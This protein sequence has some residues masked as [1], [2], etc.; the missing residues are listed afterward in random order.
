MGL[1]FYIKNIRYVNLLTKY[2]DQSTLPTKELV[3]Y[4]YNLLKLYNLDDEC[5]VATALFVL[6]PKEEVNYDEISQEFSVDVAQ[7]LKNLNSVGIKP[8]LSDS[9]EFENIRNMLIVMSQD[10]RVLII[11]LAF[12]VFKIEHLD[13][14]PIEEQKVFVKSVKEIYA[15]LSARLSLNEIKNKMEDACFKFLEPEMYEQLSLD[16]RLNKVERQQQVD[17]IIKKIQQELT[18]MGIKC[19]VYGREKHLASVYNKIKT[20]QV[21]LGQ[22]Y[23]LMAI[24]VIVDT[25]EECYTVLGKINSMFSILPNRFKDYIATPK[26]NGY[27]SIHT[28]I[29]ADNNRPVE[30]QIRTQQMHHFNEYG[31]AAHWIYKDK[32]HKA[33]NFDKSINWLKELIDENKDLSGKEFAQ[34]VKMDMFNSEIYAQ[35]PNGKIIKFPVGANCIDFAYA[36]H[37]NIGNRCVGAKIN[38]KFMPLTTELKNGDVCEILLGA[39][40]KG[41]SRDWLKVVKT[42]SARSKINNY[43]KKQFVESNI[44]NGKAMF[45]ASAR[46]NQVSV[47]TL[48]NGDKV[49][50]LLSK[51]SLGDMDEIYAMIGTGTLSSDGIVK[52]LMPARQTEPTAINYKPIKVKG[53]VLVDNNRG[54]MTRFAKCCLPLPGDEIVGFVSLGKGVTIHRNDCVNVKTLDNNRFIPVSW[55]EDKN[56]IYLA[57]ISVTGE[58]EVIASITHLLEKLNVKINSFEV[59]PLNPSQYII[60]LT[61]KSSEELNKTIN[62]IKQINKV[63]SV[64]RM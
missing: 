51:Y 10:V 57:R 59:N 6:K 34:S 46:N 58:S 44:R 16:E 24:R 61:L 54:M 63:T 9:A 20:K 8:T 26:P 45:E 43:F 11:L 60:T 39:E 33:S 53:N 27:Q 14:M 13:L 3:F 29:L 12:N 2:L 15:P 35:T 28:C 52:R 48:L 7:I 31:V 1:D 41:P 50:A 37:T 17:N 4:M 22:I 62:K 19:K 40:N 49:D 42:S 36:V 32:T 25:I 30:V 64:E 23:D 5:F 18:Q 21:T 56:S 55:D 38:G 47:N